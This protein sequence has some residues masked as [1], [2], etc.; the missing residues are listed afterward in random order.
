[1]GVK[2][3]RLLT[4]KVIGGYKVGDVIGAACWVMLH[5]TTHTLMN[6]EKISG[7]QPQ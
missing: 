5:P 3:V 4:V 2:V 1:V 6:S 7:R